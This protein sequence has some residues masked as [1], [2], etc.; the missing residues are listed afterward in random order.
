MR[1]RFSW[2]RSVTTGIP[3]RCTGFF[4]GSIIDEKQFA[5]IGGKS[6]AAGGAQGKVPAKPPDLRGAESLHPASEQ[7]GNQKLSLET[8]E[9]AVLDRT[10]ENR[11]VP[12]VHPRRN[13]QFLA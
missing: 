10:R 1:S 12:S 7:T 6:E 13:Q 9:V 4:D 11:K 2:S 3:T 5:V 8:L